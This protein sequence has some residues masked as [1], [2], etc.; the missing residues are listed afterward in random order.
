M[1]QLT[2]LARTASRKR[3]LMRLR[4]YAAP[5]CRDATKANCAGAAADGSPSLQSARKAAT[6]RRPSGE[7]PMARTVR[8]FFRRHRRGKVSPGPWADRDC[9]CI[10]VTKVSEVASRVARPVRA[11]WCGT[12]GRITST[13]RGRSGAC[14]PWRDDGEGHRVPDASPCGRENRDRPVF[15]DSMVEMFSSLVPCFGIREV[16][17]I[18]IFCPEARRFGERH[19]ERAVGARTQALIGHWVVPVRHALLRCHLPVAKEQRS[20]Y[21]VVLSGRS[22][23]VLRIRN[24]SEHCTH[25]NHTISRDPACLTT[26]D[27]AACSVWKVSTQSCD[28]SAVLSQEE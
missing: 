5:Q 8:G 9:R 16:V 6:R 23:T 10:A 14:A 11:E 17:R 21:I 18:T 28:P 15:C 13:L 24:C 3:R 7:S 26:Q 25:D 12:V 2:L 19:P 4:T 27:P 1:G 22:R 20:P